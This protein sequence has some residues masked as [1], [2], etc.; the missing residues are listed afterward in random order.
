MEL[1][2]VWP[3]LFKMLFELAVIIIIPTQLAPVRKGVF[4]TILVAVLAVLVSDI[5]QLI[6]MSLDD[7]DY[8][9]RFMLYAINGIVLM[10]TQIIFWILLAVFVC[11]V[12]KA[13]AH[14]SN[15]APSPV[16]LAEHPSENGRGG[17]VLTFGILG[18]LL[19]WPL[20]LAA[21]IMGA[22]DLG[23]VQ[24]GAKYSEKNIKKVRYGMTLGIIATL[25]PII[26]FLSVFGIALLR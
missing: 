20:G 26:F 9:R 1:A 12:A 23:K 3:T 21:W 16:A 22:S 5:S 10:A 18:I 15:V 14:K 19:F 2:Y 8:P 25:L 7:Y 11:Q 17:L 4:W 13:L 24:K 6:T